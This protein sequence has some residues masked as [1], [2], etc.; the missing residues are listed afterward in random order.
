MC[1]Y[2]YIYITPLLE[3]IHIYFNRRMQTLISSEK[4]FSR[5]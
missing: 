4:S 5:F 3:C 1:I 2:I